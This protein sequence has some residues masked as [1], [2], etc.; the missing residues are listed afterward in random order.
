MAWT[1]DVGRFVLGDT[2]VFTRRDWSTTRRKAKR[3]RLG[4]GVDCVAMRVEVEGLEARHARSVVERGIVTWSNSRATEE[5]S[6]H[7]AGT[8]NKSAPGPTGIGYKLLKWCHAAEPL[9]LTSLFTMALFLGYHPW[10]AAT[11]VPIPKPNKPDYREAKAYRPISLLE[12]CGKLLEKIVAKRVLTDSLKYA[13][14]PPSQFGSWDHHTAADAVLAVHH[15]IRSC[16]KAGHVGALFLF[17]I[18]GFFDNL[19]V[20]RLVHLFSL[21]GFPTILCAWLR[22]FLTDRRV[23]LS[24]NGIPLPEIVLEHGTPQGPHS[25]LSSP[26]S[27]R[28]LS[29][30]TPR[31]GSISLS[32]C[33]LT[34]APSLVLARPTASLWTLRAAL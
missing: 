1:F 25:H 16:V 3:V 29:S 14:L 20:D 10:K 4:K 2:R 28:C 27:T 26:Q 33:T 19:H 31:L 24:F 18:Q 23:S 22:S 17:D 5:I 8:S 9:R 32:Q 7:L 21:L 30:W 15:S 13:L 34:M 11:I 6:L 12:C